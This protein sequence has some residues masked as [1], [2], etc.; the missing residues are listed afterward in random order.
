MRAMTA[1]IAFPTL[2]QDFFCKRLI[3]E[4]NASAQTVHSYR[5]TFRLLLRYL[6]KCTGKSAAALS[7]E[8]MDASAVLGFLDHIEHE[9]GNSPRSRNARLAAIR[10]FMNYV[11]FRDPASL[12]IA[13]QVLAIPLKRFE[14]SPLVF[15]S[16]E[17]MDAIL[18]ACN[19]ASWSGFRDRVMLKTLYNTGA[20]V[21]EII[22]MKQSDLNLGRESSVVLHGK[23]RKQR[24]MPLWKSTTRELE[25]WLRRDGRIDSRAEA[26]VFPNREG[27][28]LSRSGIEYRLRIHVKEAAREHP[29]LL[30]KRVS[31][32]CI[33][34]TTALHLLQSGVDISVIAL[35]LGHERLETTHAYVEADMAMKERALSA[36]QEPRG[37][38]LRYQPDPSL[39]A[40]LEGL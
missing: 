35:W 28:A 19:T 3:G 34:H 32:H 5:D 10:T 14:Q 38:E 4:R 8:D 24:A 18:D 25:A 20:R 23:G 21:S 27:G 37:G 39:L 40:F 29:S 1:P 2:V 22:A 30:G 26:P 17:E 12:G 36:L 15:L 7:L 13:H 31:P 33:R 9:R 6:E 11:C 16:R